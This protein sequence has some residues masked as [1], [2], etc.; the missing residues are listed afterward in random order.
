MPRLR[1]LQSPRRVRDVV[2]SLRH[3][4]PQEADRRRRLLFARQEEGLMALE[5]YE[6]EC[7]WCRRIGQVNPAKN[8]KNGET[9]R[10]NCPVCGHEVIVLCDY[11]PAFFAYL[12][13]SWRDE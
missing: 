1:Q 3:W 7:P 13:E 5:W 4:V 6:W 2:L 11:Q 10:M 9:M 8:Y 12:P